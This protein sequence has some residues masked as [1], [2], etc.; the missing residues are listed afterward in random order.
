[1]TAKKIDKT[2]EQ[3]RRGVREE[4]REHPLFGKRTIETLVTNHIT[5]HPYMYRR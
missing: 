2:S 1:M 3:F 4:T 5:L